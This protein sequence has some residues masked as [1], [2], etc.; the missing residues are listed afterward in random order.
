MGAAPA[1]PSGVSDLGTHTT[2]HTHRRDALNVWCKEQLHLGVKIYN[3]R[4][5]SDTFVLMD[6]KKAEGVHPWK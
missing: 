3:I 1:P 4:N 2:R 6:S 5:N